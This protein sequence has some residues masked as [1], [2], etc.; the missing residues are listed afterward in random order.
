MSD[1]S[2]IPLLALIQERGLVDDLQLEE[3]AQEHTRSGKP[4]IQTLQ[5]FGLLDLETILQIMADHLGTEVVELH[6]LELAP[7]VLQTVPASAARMH[8]CLP[9]AVYGSSVRIAMADPL[10]PAVADRV[11]GA[12]GG[13]RQLLPARPRQRRNVPDISKRI[14]GDRRRGPCAAGLRTTPGRAGWVE[15]S[16][17]PP[18]RPFLFYSRISSVKRFFSFIPAAPRMVRIERAV[19]PCLP[20]TLPRSEG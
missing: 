7:E 8:Q 1:I 9:V 18:V 20:I 13:E 2:S 19:R 4:V 10:D 16:N 14:S 11:G 12:R 3:V 5:D 6:N 15:G 17:R